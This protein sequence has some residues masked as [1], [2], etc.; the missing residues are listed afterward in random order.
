MCFSN[1]IFGCN[2]EDAWCGRE[3]DV[4]GHSREVWSIAG[5]LTE[6]S[7]V[8]LRRT[9]DPDTEAL[10]MPELPVCSPVCS[11]GHVALTATD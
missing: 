11:P 1:H 8:I 10:C 5:A 2:F 7:E 6:E 3:E 4:P 9:S